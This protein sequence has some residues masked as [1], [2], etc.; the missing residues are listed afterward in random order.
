VLLVLPPTHSIFSLTV[1][2]TGP[3]GGKHVKTSGGLIVVPDSLQILPTDTEK[4]CCLGY[5]KHVS[6]T[7]FVPLITCCYFMYVFR[8]SR[9]RRR[10]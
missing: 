4:V 2:S 1:F 10:S 9:K 3:I 5:V 8:K 7:V 6:H